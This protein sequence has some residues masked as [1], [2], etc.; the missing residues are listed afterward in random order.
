[1]VEC[2]HYVLQYKIF[3]L[4]FF[5]IVVALTRTPISTLLVFSGL[6]AEVPGPL[7]P[8]VKDLEKDR[9]E[10]VKETTAF[11]RTKKKKKRVI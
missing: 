8:P 7:M 3:I 6:R 11:S 5:P 2:E 1:M 4:L 9:P 10:K